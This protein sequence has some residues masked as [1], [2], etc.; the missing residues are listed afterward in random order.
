MDLV[1]YI[2]FICCSCRSEINF[3]KDGPDVIDTVIGSGVHL[4]NVEDGTVKDTLTCGAL[5]AWIAVYGMLA[6]DRSCEDL[7]DRGLARAVLAAE[8][9]SVSELLRYYRLP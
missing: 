7:G 8:K 3:L 5:V 9:I 2:D 1:D 4:C 6:V